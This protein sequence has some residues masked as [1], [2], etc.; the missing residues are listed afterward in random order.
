MAG[1]NLNRNQ[2]PATVDDVPED[3]ARDMQAWVRAWPSVDKAIADFKKAIQDFQAKNRELNQK[4]G[5]KASDR[6]LS[7][8]QREALQNLVA[9]TSATNDALERLL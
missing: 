3:L 7:R 4:A 9:R 1:L 8:E 5:R 6:S 2:A